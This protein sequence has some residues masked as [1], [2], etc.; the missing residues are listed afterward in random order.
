MME[1]GICKMLDGKRCKMFEGRG[2]CTSM[3]EGRRKMEEL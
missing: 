3:L 2:K 1:D